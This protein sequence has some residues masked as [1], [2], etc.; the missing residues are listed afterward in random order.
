M[1]MKAQQRR[2]PRPQRAWWQHQQPLQRELRPRRR[3]RR[4]WASP[5]AFWPPVVH[6]QCRLH[7]P[8]A[9]QRLPP[10]RLPLRSGPRQRQL[11]RQRL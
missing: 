5:N 8:V 1:Q 10:L 6:F 7:H 2:R 9:C 4:R 11:L 3:L